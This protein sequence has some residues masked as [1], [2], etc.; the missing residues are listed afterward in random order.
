[1]IDSTQGSQQ[2]PVILAVDDEP[3]VLSAITRDLRQQYGSA[4]RIVRDTSARAAL[5]TLRQIKLRGEPVALILTDQRMPE[6]TG[7]D[8]LAEA[9][10]IFPDAKRALL[11]AYADTEVA[12]R[13]INE[14][15]LHHYLQKP[16]DP[17][18]ERLYPVVDDLLDDWQAG[19]RREFGGLRIVGHRWSAAAHQIKELLARNLVPYRWMDID[20]DADAARLLQVADLAVLRPD[21]RGRR[22]GGTR[23]G[24][25]WR[26]GRTQNV[27]NRA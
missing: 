9:L 17:P 8:L 11:T 25:L 16:W 12:I 7:V 15:G 18:A 1:V 20:S 4:Y 27:A 14:I 10:P 24:G 23:G 26:V 6:M 5:D 19:Y 21:H 22:A 3:N 2:K 13:A